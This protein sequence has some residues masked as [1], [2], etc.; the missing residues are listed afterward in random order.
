MLCEACGSDTWL[1]QK[2]LERLVSDEGIAVLGRSGSGKY[3]QPKRRDHADSERS[4]TGIDQV[5][6][7]S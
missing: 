3:V 7:H 4:I 5:N 2:T 6:A 1:D